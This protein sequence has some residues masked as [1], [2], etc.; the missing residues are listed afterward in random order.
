MTRRCA[1]AALFLACTG[2]D[3]QTILWSSPP[4][5]TNQV[6]SGQPMHAGFRFELGVFAGTFTPSAG[7]LSQ[8]ST[9]W[10]PIQRVQYNSDSKR[11]AGEYTP[12]NNAS[13]F[14]IGKTVYIW[15]FSGNG[16]A[17]EWILFRA[18]SWLFPDANPIGPP[19]LNDWVANAS[20]VTAIIGTIQSGGSQFLMRS[21]SVAGV[22]P[23]ITTWAQWHAETLADGS[24]D[25]PGDDPDNDGLNNL[26][27]F[28]FGADPR[29][30]NPA[31]A[32]APSLQSA[33]GQKHLQL[34]IPRRKDHQVTL[35]VQVSSDLVQWNE[36][37][38]HVQVI[39][40]GA[41]VLVVRDLT[42]YVAGGRRFMRLKA[43]AATP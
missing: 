36:G 26:L 12:A 29:Q 24:L 5:A 37:A 28:V 33:S 13:P 43:S 2:A 41:D 16:A 14:T 10:R 17:N 34:S 40:D 35:S 39:D 18:S 8:W 23:P 25:Q 6:S 22:L 7:N 1:L 30:A 15:G 21:A 19:S 42:P 9:N 38:T 27:E 3:A 4:N 11:Y 20:G 32:M 31:P